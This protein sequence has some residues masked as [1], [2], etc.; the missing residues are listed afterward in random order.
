ML[1]GTC[2]LD[3]LKLLK[4]VLKQPC[5]EYVS[6]INP[7]GYHNL[8]VAVMVIQSDIVERRGE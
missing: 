4:F 7:S 2:I 8:N 5:V 3:Q 6:I 1:T